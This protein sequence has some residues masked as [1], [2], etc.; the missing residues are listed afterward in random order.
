MIQYKTVN[1]ARECVTNQVFI[2]LSSTTPYYYDFLITA[3]A[4]REAL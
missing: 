3:S 4:E 2:P 1:E